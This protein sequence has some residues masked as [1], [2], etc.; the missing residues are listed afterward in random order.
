M[1]TQAEIDTLAAEQA[2]RELKRT[3]AENEIKLGVL[4]DKT[5]AQVENYV[6]N[7]VTNLAEAKD[8]LKLHARI[9]LA[10]I[11]RLDLDI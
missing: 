11:K 3:E 1:Y 9:T 10:I 6:Q 5:Y 4:A 7:N 8:F 2:A